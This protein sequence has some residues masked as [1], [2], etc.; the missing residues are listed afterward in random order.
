MGV[1]QFSIQEGAQNL[2]ILYTVAGLIF[3]ASAMLVTYLL[4]RFSCFVVSSITLAIFS[5]VLFLDAAL[6][7]YVST[8]EIGQGVALGFLF[9]NT[10]TIIELSESIMWLIPAAILSTRK[11]KQSFVIVGIAFKFGVLFGSILVQTSASVITPAMFLALCTTFMGVAAGSVAVIQHYSWEIK[12]E[13]EDTSIQDFA[14]FLLKNRY[15]IV[16]IF[17]EILV[18]LCYFSLEYSFNVIAEFNYPEQTA[19]MT[20]YG[21][22]EFAETLFTSIVSL[23]AFTSI[24]NRLGV[25]HTFNLIPALFSLLFFLYYYFGKNAY[26]NMAIGMMSVMLVE[27]SLMLIIIVYKAAA[28]KFRN[29]IISLSDSF[30]LFLGMALAGLFGLLLQ[31]GYVDFQNYCLILALA[32]AAIAA[33]AYISRHNYTKA[34]AQGISSEQLQQLGQENFKLP[35]VQKAVLTLW[36]TDDVDAKKMG[37]QVPI[38]VEDPFVIRYY[39]KV[40]EGLNDKDREVRLGALHS[41]VR[42]SSVIDILEPIII[43]RLADI[44]PQVRLTALRT[45]AECGVTDLE[46]YQNIIEELKDSKNKEIQ[47]EIALTIGALHLTDYQSLLMTYLDASN[48]EVRLGALRSIKKLLELQPREL[49]SLLLYRL[50]EKDLKVAEEIITYLEDLEDYIEP[51]NFDIFTK[52]VWLWRNTLKLMKQMEYTEHKDYVIQSAV[53]NMYSL[54]EQLLCIETLNIIQDEEPVHFLIDYIREKTALILE[55]T[56]NIAFFDMYSDDTHTKYVYRHLTDGHDHKKGNAIEMLEHLGNPKIVQILSP[57]FET[58]KLKFH[59]KIQE[60]LSAT[61]HRWHLSY[62]FEELL[63]EDDRWVRAC[64]VHAMRCLSL[65]EFIPTLQRLSETDPSDLVRNNAYYSIKVISGDIKE[66]DDMKEIEQQALLIENIMFLKRTEL[67]S[68]LTL[69]ELVVIVQNIELCELEPGELLFSLEDP[70]KGVYLIMSGEVELYT[71]NPKDK[72]AHL[73]STKDSLG[74]A[75]FYGS[76]PLLE[77]AVAKTKTKAFFINKDNFANILEHYPRIQAGI[78]SELCKIVRRYE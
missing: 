66:G 17:I 58:E 3:F 35:I 11:A 32:S 40:L 47:E 38:L 67:F 31:F 78:I 8:H 34:L 69:N 54:Y 59:D 19:L 25:W 77:K 57:F 70:L 49:T 22:F 42:F 10:K 46:Q 48:Y 56:I 75:S 14:E 1:T 28:Q 63:S 62:V 30:G 16:I 61:M 23:V 41:A 20:Y 36:N 6:T 71:R 72:D 50:S 39:T 52:D 27:Y 21:R 55:T 45:L 9:V 43:K 76:D 64:I 29:L 13:E 4:T 15:W 33:Y 65:D 7:W 74:L 51:D 2:S 44:D 68:S 24:L 53:V 5:G 18:L 37:L 26:L 73:L 60:I 12:E